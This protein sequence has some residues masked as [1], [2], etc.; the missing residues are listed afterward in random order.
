MVQCGSTHV[1]PQKDYCS[2]KIHLIF[3]LLFFKIWKTAMI[4]ISPLKVIWILVEKLPDAMR[5]F[6]RIG[7]RYGTDMANWR[8]CCWQ[9]T[10][11]PSDKPEAHTLVERLRSSPGWRIKAVGY[12]V[13]CGQH[14]NI[15]TT[16]YGDAYDP[17]LLPWSSTWDFCF[18]LESFLVVSRVYFW[19]CAQVSLL[20]VFW[21]P[22]ECW[23][24]NLGQCARLAF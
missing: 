17:I 18:I 20:I 14:F 21:G 8:G 1:L 12:M 23:G 24:L 5:I 10:A 7:K 22:K 3:N 19:H 4:E 11:G 16:E 13:G 9:W 15:L 6:K 2:E